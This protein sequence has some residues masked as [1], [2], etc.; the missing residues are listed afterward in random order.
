ML[1]HG[2]RN[3]MSV[4]RELLVLNAFD[5]LCGLVLTEGLAPLPHT[6]LH[7]NAFRTTDIVSGYM[8]Q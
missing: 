1:L 3:A 8:A 2:S 5:F 4:G 7:S 6:P